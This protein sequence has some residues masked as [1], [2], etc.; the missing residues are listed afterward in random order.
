MTYP[1]P[2]SINAS[3]GIVEV[4]DYVNT[5]SDH[6]ISNMF[7]LAVYIIF[8]IGYYKA[9]D[10]FKGALGVAGYGVFVVG[11]LFWIGGFITGWAFGIAIAVAIV[12]T[13]VLLMDNN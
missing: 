3:Q 8:L 9:K 12:G 1:Q 6:W 10:D 7:L 4:L 13:L 11:L 5:V 2:S